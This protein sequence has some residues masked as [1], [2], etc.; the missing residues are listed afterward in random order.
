MAVAL[1]R[2]IGNMS[3]ASLGAVILD[4]ISKGVVLRCENLCGS[5]L[6]ATQAA[7]HATFEEAISQLTNEKQAT[8][9]AVHSF[10]AELNLLVMSAINA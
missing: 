6:L 8:C 10:C 5:A 9:F 7:F 2:A 4:D 3:S 1:R